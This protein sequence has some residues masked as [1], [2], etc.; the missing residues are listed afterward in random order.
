MV[1]QRDK[2]RLEGEKGQYI[3]EIARARGKISETEMQVLQ[4]DQD[5]RT[6]VLKDMRDTPGPDRGIAGAVHGGRRSAQARRYPR[7]AVRHV[8]QLSVHT[9]GGVI[10]NGEVVMM[11]VPRADALVVEA[12]VAP[13]DIDQLAVGAPATVRIMAG[14]QR[15]MQDISATLTASPP[16]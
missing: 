12:K 13:Q 11:I 16:I 14:N 15:I 1:L 9:V 4:L 3:A 5:F 2:A 10:A 7:A 6:E 8:H